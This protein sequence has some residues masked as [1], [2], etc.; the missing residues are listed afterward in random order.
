[1]KQA[2]IFEPSIQSTDAL[3]AQSRDDEYLEEQEERSLVKALRQQTKAKRFGK[4]HF[5]P[6]QAK[7]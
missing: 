7:Q 1:M 4:Q 5:N 6:H 3:E 2:A